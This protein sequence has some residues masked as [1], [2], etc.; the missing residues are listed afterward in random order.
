VKLTECISAPEQPVE[1]GQ[2][3]VPKPNMSRSVILCVDKAAGRVYCDHPD[4][5][6]RSWISIGSLIKRYTL[7]PQAGRGVA[8]RM[9]P[10][11]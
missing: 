1:V 11:P 10:R 5:R 9:E 8:D 4:S 6:Q 2:V 7:E 3:Y